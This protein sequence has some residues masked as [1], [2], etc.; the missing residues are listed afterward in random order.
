MVF[1]PAFLL[2]GFIAVTWALATPVF[3]SPDENAHAA[4]AIAQVHGELLPHT[5]EGSRQPA[6]DLPD[7]YLYSP[8]VTCFA[9]SPQVTASCHAELGSLGG[10]NWFGDWVGSYNPV[11][12]YAVGWPSLFLGGSTG[13]YA[14]RIVSAL[15]CSALLA[16]AFV[17]AFAGRRAR[18]MPMGLAFL[19]APMTMF[20]AGSVNPQGVEFSGGALLAIAL[21]RLLERSSRPVD[22]AFSRRNLWI[23]VTIGATVLAIARATGPLWVIVIVVGIFVV[24]GIRQSLT[25]FRERSSYPWLAVIVGF[26][27]F[28]VLWTLI[29]GSLSAQA[30]AAD[31]PLVGGTFV[32]GFWVM[33]R[34]T[35]F[36]L[37][38]AAGIFGWQDTVLPAVGYS[39]FF[40]AL[41]ILFSLAFSGTGRRSRLVVVAALAAAVLVPAVVQAISVS[42][43]GI[44]WQG[45]YGLFLYLAVILVAAWLLS[46]DAPKIASLSVPMTAIVAALLGVYGVGAFVVV[47]HRYV[48]GSGGTVGEML[49]APQWQPPLGWPALV[50][51]NL[52][53]VAAFSAWNGRAAFLVARAEDRVVAE[54]S[55]Q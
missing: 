54:A 14:M 48:V 32:Q 53:A 31:A 38:S 50:L 4:K 49:S 35:P 30:E 51:L 24:F 40:G 18:W 41:A 37:Q 42:R 55:P 15:L 7:S 3:A 11:Y 25:L 52:L 29:T 5:R 1:L 22:G 43:T 45:R 12:Y 28:S 6:Y 39:L 17:A 44:I 19:A 23:L 27:L 47:L 2:I 46:H 16:G 13:I 9:F 20:L 36:Y 8:G 10:T 26:G 21:L 34:E 33:L